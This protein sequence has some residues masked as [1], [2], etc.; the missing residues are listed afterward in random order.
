M[1]QVDRAAQEQSGTSRA[2]VGA[3]EEMHR[4][5]RQVS[6]A[7]EEQARASAHVLQ[8][9]Q[10][11]DRLAQHVGQAVEE[12]RRSADVIVSAIDEVHRSAQHVAEAGNAI[13]ADAHS[14]YAKESRLDSAIAGFRRGDAPA[15]GS[16]T[17][18]TLVVPA[19]APA[20]RPTVGV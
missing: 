16:A 14:L 15:P 13:T 2:I 4:L 9:V 17:T 20:P 7:T 19:T 12:Q 8:E 1:A 11:M 6:G 10:T 3:V 5:T 18:D